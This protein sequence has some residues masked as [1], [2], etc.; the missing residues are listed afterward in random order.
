MLFPRSLRSVHGSRS[1]NRDARRD[2]PCSCQKSPFLNL[3]WSIHLRRLVRKLEVRGTSSNTS[4]HRRFSI[5]RS[6]VPPHPATPFPPARSADQAS[7]T[8]VCRP[9][10]R[11]RRLRPMSHP[12]HPLARAAGQSA[13]TSWESPDVS[14]VMQGR[15]D[16][17][18][19]MTRGFDDEAR[20]RIFARLGRRRRVSGA[21][22]RCTSAR[23]LLTCGYPDRSII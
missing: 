21:A 18:H 16:A 11:P 15:V 8:T 17:S 1:S 22:T 5:S 13:R 7:A 19:I 2:A 6:I 23:S 20:V 3:R 9:G 12:R 14:D 10:V 4:C